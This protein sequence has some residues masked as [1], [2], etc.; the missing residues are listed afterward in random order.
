MID[1]PI[2]VLEARD[3][4]S[5][6]EGEADPD[7]KAQQ[8]EKAID[9]L[10]AYEAEHPEASESTLTFVTNIR[11]SHTRRLLVQLLSLKRVDIVT[12]LQYMKLLVTRLKSEVD[13]AIAQDP[14]LCMNYNEF[15]RVW[16]DVL[17]DELERRRL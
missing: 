15:L 9:L 6:A 17:R 7:Q 14:T 11:H 12:W 10:D 1:V 13:F 16:D 4:L 3:L 8:L 5:E 2:D